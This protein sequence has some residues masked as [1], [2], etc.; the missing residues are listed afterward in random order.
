MNRNF[1]G[2]RIYWIVMVITM[3][4]V[5]LTLNMTSCERRERIIKIGSQAVLS[6]EYKAFGEDQLV[7]L[8]LAA[9][10]LSPV[11]IGG[12][13]Y[14]I[15]L[16][17]RDDE[18]S[19]EKAFLVAQELAGQGALLV[20]GST[21]DGTTRVS[22]PVYEEY[23]IPLVSPFAQKTETALIGDN[24]FR[25]IINNSQKIDNI[26]S[27]ILGHTEE[28]KLVLIDNR[29]EYS[30]ELID[31]LEKELL[32]NGKD[33]LRRYSIEGD[34]D[35]LTIL[36]DNILIDA[37][38]Y[39][40][41]ALDY[42]E[43]AFLISEVKKTIIEPV[44]ITETLGM[45]EHIFN[46]NG[47]KDLDGLLAIIPEPPSVAMS[48]TDQVAVDFWHQ[49]NELLEI[50]KEDMNL[51][52]GRPGDYSAYV[53]DSLMLSIKAMKS[54]NSVLPQDFIQELKKTSYDGITGHIE[55]DSNGDRMNP[56]STVFIVRNG[57]WA[58][59]N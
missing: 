24:F 5:I 17:T 35:N 20:I 23:N 11:S 30:I 58:R 2:S 19:P 22:I 51:S 56:P 7:S 46:V 15:E 59:Y 12:F 32:T 31:Y 3:M 16:I 4:S 47:G 27:F 14:N 26:A 54:A 39:I 43:L 52:I 40:F 57:I 9:A 44:F 48:T 55:F 25:V 28:G 33:I 45:S 50:L 49:Y 21:F 42:I 13:D 8:E 37:P 36:A 18:G 6:E 38:D 1:I 41:C 34:E 10:A 29:K 53:Y